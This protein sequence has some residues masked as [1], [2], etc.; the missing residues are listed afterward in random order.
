MQNKLQALY[1]LEEKIAYLHEVYLRGEEYHPL[2]KK[3]KKIFRLLSRSDMA[4]ERKLKKFF[5]NQAKRSAKFINWEYNKKQL[6]NIHRASLI[7]YFSVNWEGEILKMRLILTD[8]LIDALV[9]GGLLTQ[10][11]TKINI[12]WNEKKAPAIEFIKNHTLKLAG[13]ITKTT[14]KRI[15]KS[16]ALS[17]DLGENM[18]AAAIRFAKIFDD[19]RRAAVIAHTESVRAFTEGRLEVGRRVGADRKQWDATLNACKICQPMDGEIVKI[20]KQFKKAGD[21]VSRDAPPA[22]PNCRC[23]I[24]ILMPNEK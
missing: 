4:T 10:L 5:K 1:K 17:I 22:H 7:D 14:I 19:P 16:L 21:G 20:N 2:Y 8:S 12:G 13:Q 18:S 15:L 11:E 9:A 3:H 23:I 24:K 6:K